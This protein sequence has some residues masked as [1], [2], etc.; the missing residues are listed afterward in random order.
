MEVVVV[1]EVLLVR[2]EDD[3]KDGEEDGVDL[4]LDEEEGEDDEDGV[5]AGAR[6]IVTLEPRT[7]PRESPRELPPPLPRELRYPPPSLLDAPSLPKPDKPLCLRPE[8]NS[9]CFLAS[10]A[11]RSPPGFCGGINGSILLLLW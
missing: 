10:I 7:S 4:C 8:D 5:V 11:R 1:V 6:R 9:F 2:M 3:G